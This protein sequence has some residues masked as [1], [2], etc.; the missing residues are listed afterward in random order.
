M[1]RYGLSLFGSEVLPCGKSPW[2]SQC[3]W[4]CIFDIMLGLHLARSAFRSRP[5]PAFFARQGSIIAN[6]PLPTYDPSIFRSP[7]NSHSPPG[8][9]DPSGSMRSVRL[10]PEKLAIAGCPICF[11][12]PSPCN[13]ELPLCDG[14]TLRLRLLPAWLAA[15]LHLGC[16]GVGLVLDNRT[17]EPS[18]PIQWRR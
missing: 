5:C 1:S 2:P 10:H 13:N 7:P 8:P 12:S 6:R 11:R 4:P 16:R 9:L 17:R 18:P 3:S 14:S 15:R